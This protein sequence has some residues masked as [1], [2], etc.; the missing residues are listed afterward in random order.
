MSENAYLQIQRCLPMLKRP[1][2]SAKTKHVHKK[3]AMYKKADTYKIIN[4]HRNDNYL[5]K[6]SLYNKKWWQDTQKIP[7]AKQKT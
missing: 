1:Q 3:S 5:T 7:R 6:K 4:V 2:H